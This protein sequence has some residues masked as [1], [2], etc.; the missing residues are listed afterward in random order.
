MTLA[1]KVKNTIETLCPVCF[2]LYAGYGLHAGNALKFPQGIQ[3][4]EKRNKEGRCIK[5]VYQYADDSKLTYTYS[6][7]T[8]KF[9]LKI[10]A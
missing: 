3:L 2:S 5:A 6:D 9:T 1:S 4:S 8:H 7:T 10:E